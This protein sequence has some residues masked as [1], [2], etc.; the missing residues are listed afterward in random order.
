[1]EQNLRDDIRS[2]IC[3]ITFFKNVIGRIYSNINSQ[4][5]L[6]DNKSVVNNSKIQNAS[7]N[8]DFNE[9]L[10]DFIVESENNQDK[11]NG[12]IKN[13][14]GK[15]INDIVETN[16]NELE[17]KSNDNVDYNN[18]NKI[19]TIEKQLIDLRRRRHEEYLDYRLSTNKISGNEKEA[20]YLVPNIQL[21]S[22][23]SN[24]TDK[25]SLGNLSGKSIKKTDGKGKK[26]LANTLKKQK[27]EKDNQ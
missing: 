4:A 3:E 8:L 6:I 19:I 9:S 20:S 13:N 18:E 22:S 24:K 2:L 5:S 12:K 17:L 23:K 11:S 21:V 10:I 16:R 14:V 26:N 25:T 27:K 15:E 1:M 7:K